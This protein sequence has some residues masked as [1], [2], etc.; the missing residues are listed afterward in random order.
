VYEAAQ[1]NFK[2]I[3]VHKIL[4]SIKQK[5]HLPDRFIL[6]VGTL[7]PRK[8]IIRLL[9]AYARIK[10]K[11]PHKLVIAGTKGWLYQPIFE[12]V[13]RLS[14]RNNVIFLGYVDDGNLPALYNLADL[15]VYPSIYEGFGLPVLEAMACGIPVITSNVSSLP[16]VAGDAAVLVDPYNV[17]ELAGAMKHVLTNASLRKQVINKGFQQAKNFSWKKCARETLKVYEEVYDK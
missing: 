17:K 15:F 6:F 9:E 16:E 10:D 7:E 13:K 14:L 12:A 8:N 1:N 3:Q 11:L 5:Y 2:R 4:N